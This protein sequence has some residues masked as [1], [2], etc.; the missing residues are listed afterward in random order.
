MKKATWRPARRRQPEV[1][2]WVSGS[3]PD[4]RCRK[5]DLRSF[6]NMVGG[7]GPKRD[8]GDS[9]F[10][11]FRSGSVDPGTVRRRRRGPRNKK[12]G[13]RRLA[14][15]P[16]GQEVDT[17]LEDVR[18]QE[19]ATGGLLSETP[20]ENLFFVDKGRG[21]EDSKIK[22][23][24][25]KS[26]WIDRVL[27]SNSKVPSPKNILAHQVPNGKKLKRKQRLWEHLAQQGKQPR[28]VRKAQARL[29]QPPTPKT[30]PS[31]PADRPFYD[32]W[33]QDNPLDRPLVGQ[34]TFF[35][36]QTKKKGVKRPRRLQTKPSQAPAVEVI[37]SGGSYNPSFQAHQALLQEAHE[38]ELQRQKVEEKLSRQLAFPTVDK[39][40]TQESAFKELCE[41]LLE[42]SDEETPAEP[43]DG[44]ADGPAPR[45]PGPEKK[46]E[47]QRRREKEA[48]KL[49]AQQAAERA[50]RK[51]RQEVFQ[52]RGIRLQ[53]AQRLTE[54]ARRRE[55][56][57]LKRLAEDEKPRRLG[58]LKYQ[59]PDIDVQLSTELADSLRKLK[60]EGSIL[61]DRFKSFQ[62]RN[63]IEPRERARFKRKYKVKLVEKR[64]F[65]EMQ[66]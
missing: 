7:R 30:P 23:D 5:Y 64:A 28:E 9:G 52:L 2:V 59:A 6:C 31:D 51:R 25:K 3:P 15:E 33:A 18:L 22:Q 20:D 4:I 29:L 61:R 17:F 53:V 57:R 38:V 42:E 26:F 56:R 13:W 34:D 58:R 16:L 19:R 55:R 40:P 45:P 43:G 12:R 54:L 11:G 32:L 60:P 35:L 14:E 49:K 24:L 46:T 39:A 27:E 1:R 8:A 47:Q 21:E 10:L 44:D 41:G 50:A 63:M 48:R 62:R 66:L 65:R 37:P 36:E